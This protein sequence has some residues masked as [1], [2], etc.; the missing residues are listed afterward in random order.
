MCD[1]EEGRALSHR[2]FKARFVILEFSQILQTKGQKKKKTIS[3]NH[4][5][6]LQISSINY[7]KLVIFSSKWAAFGWMFDRYS[8]CLLLH[9]P[10]KC[11]VVKVENVTKVILDSIYLQTQTDLI[12]LDYL[13]WSCTVLTLSGALRRLSHSQ[14]HSQCAS[15]FIYVLHVQYAVISSNNYTLISIL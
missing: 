9:F 6:Q 2:T 10:L 4:Y 1:Q 13:L 8:F 15:Y 12:M 14:K 7:V 5:S 3:Y 11:S